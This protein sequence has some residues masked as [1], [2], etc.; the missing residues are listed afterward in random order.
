MQCINQARFL[1]LGF[2]TRS[3][4]SDGDK[5]S[6]AQLFTCKRSNSLRK[7]ARKSVSTYCDVRGTATFIA[8]R[9]ERAATLESSVG[10]SARSNG[11][12]STCTFLF[13]RCGVVSF[14]GCGDRCCPCRDRGTATSCAD[15]IE[16]CR[17]SSSCVS[18]GSSGRICFATECTEQS[19][20]G[21]H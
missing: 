14:G 16:P 11:R 13:H 18:S 3:V 15:S 9:Y 12:R 21:R 8:L 10:M 20:Q 6:Y 4:T 17:A 2:R 7:S 1:R 19:S 5:P